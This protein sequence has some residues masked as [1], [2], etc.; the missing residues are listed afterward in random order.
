MNVTQSRRH[1][2]RVQMASCEIKKAFVENVVLNGISEFIEMNYYFYIGGFH[3]I[4]SI[5]CVFYFLAQ[6]ELKKKIQ[7]NRVETFYKFLYLRKFRRHSSNNNSD[8]RVFWL[9]GFGGSYQ[10]VTAGTKH[11]FSSF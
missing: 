3:F 4:L 6:F 10:F 7:V 9:N 11:V 5:F 8:V 1:R 2:V